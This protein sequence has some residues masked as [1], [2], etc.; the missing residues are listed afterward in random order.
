M[1]GSQKMRDRMCDV[2]VT[3]EN[4]AED[5]HVAAVERLGGEIASGL[6]MGLPDHGRGFTWSESHGKKLGNALELIVSTMTEPHRLE[7]T[8]WHLAQKHLELGVSA[9]DLDVFEKVLFSLLEDNLPEEKY[10]EAYP[11]WKWLWDNV[12]QVFTDILEKWKLMQKHLLSSWDVL[13]ARAGSSTNISEYFYTTLFREAPLLQDLFQRRNETMVDSFAKALDLIVRCS[14][15]SSL[16][17]KELED[18]AVRHCKYDL[19]SWHFDVFG[20]ILVRCLSEVAT[21]EW[22]EEFA[23]AWRLLYNSISSVFIN[24]LDTT[25]NPMCNALVRNSVDG[26]ARALE[27]APRNE[28]VSRALYMRAGKRHLSPILWALRDGLLALVELFLDDIMAIRCDRSSYYYGVADLW[29]RCPTILEAFVEFAPDMIEQFLDGHMRVSR[30]TVNGWRTVNM[31]VRFIYGDPSLLGSVFDGPLAT[32]VD[33]L[34]E[35]HFSVFTHPVIST[36]VDL[37]WERFGKMKTIVVCF[38]QVLCLVAYLIVE[39]GYAGHEVRFTACVIWVAISSYLLF[40]SLRRI[41]RQYRIGRVATLF[42]IRGFTFVLPCYLLHFYMLLRL[43]CCILSLILTES[44]LR[45]C[46]QYS[47]YSEY[48]I[49]AG[50]NLPTIISSLVAVCQWVQLSELFKLNGKFSAMFYL[51]RTMGSDALRFMAVL[52]V[53]LLGT[54]AAL[55][56]LLKGSDVAQQ[57]DFE[58]AYA[59]FAMVLGRGD[60]KDFSFHDQGE[61]AFLVKV[62][63]M[64]ALWVSIIPILNLMVA[65]MVSTYSTAEALTVALATRAR[66][67]AVL[68]AEDELTLNERFR[69]FDSFEFEEPVRL[70]AYDK[71]PPGGINLLR[72][73]LQLKEHPSYKRREDNVLFFTGSSDPADPWP[74]HDIP[75]LCSNESR[76]PRTNGSGNGSDTVRKDIA[77]L[78]LLMENT[79]RQQSSDD[80]GASNKPPEVTQQSQMRLTQETL[81]TVAEAAA[82][83]HCFVAVDG[84]IYDVERFVSSHPGGEAVL[85]SAR[86]KDA[87]D[88]FYSKHRDVKKTMEALQSLPCLGRLVAAGKPAA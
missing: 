33:R 67:V 79:R 47:F 70:S 56:H 57:S 25:R 1:T 35:T 6:R 11:A 55:Y 77:E 85:R 13:L 28:R 31:W 39:K 83:M 40:S 32:L 5:G 23:D 80:L 42:E 53:W 19:Q 27:R 65:A 59:L 60:E 84:W 8:L 44:L 4:R 21:D 64:L 86:G 7:Q 37:K 81:K 45:G 14:S 43:C 61:D 66:T 74:A 15:D 38:Q 3:E 82:P 29:Q 9:R 54:G 36:T 75:Y 69:H 73:P 22:T 16:F 72:T 71:G 50:N 49:S 68:E 30:Q 17:D 20:E 24:V 34:P 48:C 62:L 2:T 26:A 87:T 63:F 51:A 78:K 10:E 41:F 12:S 76:G 58:T 46:W 52:I 18:L 88:D